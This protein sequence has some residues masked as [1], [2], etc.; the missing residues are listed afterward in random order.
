MK[1]VIKIGTS[2]V[3]DT[4]CELGI[5][6][7]IIERIATLISELKSKGHQV[8]LVSSGAIGLGCH[9]LNLKEKPKNITDKQAA[10]SVGQILLAQIYEEYFNKFSIITG[11]VLITRDGM[12]NKEN[13][14]NA[15][16]TINTLLKLKAVPIVN[17]N[18]VVA[19]EAIKFSDND[20]LSALVAEFI[21][22]DYM[23][24]LTDIEGLYTENP[25]NNPDAKLI[26]TV[27]EI[28]EDIENKAS[29]SSKWGTGGMSTKIIA[30]KSAVAFGT[31]VYIMH[32]QKLEEIINILEN[33]THCGTFFPAVKSCSNNSLHQS[34]IN[35]AKKTQGQLI[36][37]NTNCLEAN[38]Q[39][40][41]ISN[42]NGEFTRGDAIE[43]QH[44]NITVAKGITLYSSEDLQQIINKLQSP[45][46]EILGYTYGNNIIASSDLIKLK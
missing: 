9:K 25:N 44:N 12:Q 23:F 43:I 32:A 8:V 26:H 16:S 39:P 45:I 13:Y 6:I 14:L 41:D 18:D 33:N 40:S 22:A 7:K 21:S 27:N 37:N 4:S 38:I 1:V 2:S 20:Y 17:E 19:D 42:I 15:K 36:I 30:A 35:Y 5:N 31:N 34:W 10:A 29:G 28:T 46:D 11:Q 24:M 3:T